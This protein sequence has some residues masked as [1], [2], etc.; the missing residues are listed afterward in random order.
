MKKLSY[1]EMVAVMRTNDARYDGEF[2]VCV[3]T[4]GI[5]CLPSCKAKLPMLKNV[6]FLRTREEAIEAGF[7]GCKRCRSEF[8]PDVSPPWAETAL[9]FLRKGV[10]YKIREQQLADHIG[11][12]ISTIRRYFK[13]YME[14]T[15]MAYHRKMRLEYA[16]SLI[17]TGT[18]Y[19]TAA[20]EAGFES[21]SGFRDA[22]VKQ[23]G[24]SPGRINGH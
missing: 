12:D 22:F 7:R 24:C 14:T 9:A 18:D 5:Y 10:H 21:S 8:Y 6:V 16:H 23:Y 1:D 13:S 15:P 3:R 4:T 17:K 11:V 20:F 19:L 2:Y